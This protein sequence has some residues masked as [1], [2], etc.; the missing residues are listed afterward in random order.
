MRQKPKRILTDPFGLFCVK[1]MVRTKVILYTLLLCTSFVPVYVQAVLYEPGETLNP[2]CLPS[3]P[4]CRVAT[5]TRQFLNLTHGGLLIA[6]STP[7]ATSN[8]LYNQGGVLYWNGAV[9]GG[10]SGLTTIGP[11]GQFQ[12]GPIITLATSSTAFNGLTASTTITGSGNTL[13]FTN[14]LAGLL[15][16]GGG[17]TGIAN[18]SANG[19]LIGSTAG[20]SWQ[21]VATSSLGLV[22]S[23]VMEGTN[24]YWTQ[25]RFNAAVL[26]T[27]S[28]PHLTV[29]TSTYATVADTAATAATATVALALEG[30]NASNYLTLSDWLATTTD[31]LTEGSANLYFTNARADGRIAAATS[32]LRGMLVAGNGLA[33][34]NS[35]GVFTNSGV[36][37]L[38]GLTGN[39]ATSSL[40]IALSDTTGTLPVSRGGT[41]ITSIANNAVLIGA[42][43]TALA[44]TS[45]GDLSV[46][47]GLSLTG[48]SAALLGGS[49]TVALDIPGLTE[50]TG[51]ESS[52]TIALYDTSESGTR[53]ITRANFLQGL[54]SALTY[55][56]T[57]DANAN[58]PALTD[59]TGSAGNTYVADTATT[60]LDL[61]SGALSVN[62]GDMLI[63]NGTVWQVAPSGSNVAS[64]FGRTGA[65]AASSGDYTA[66]QITFVATSTIAATNV[67]AAIEELFDEGGLTSLNGLT[68]SA[69]AFDNDTNV[70][71]SSAGAT[72]TL[73]WSGQLAA[74]RGG[75][76]L[77]S[78]TAHQLLIG[79]SAGDGWTQVATS[80][81]GL[82]TTDVAEGSNLYWT[83]NRFNTALLATSS[84]M[85]LSVSTST[86]AAV[87]DTA[88][89]AD[90]ATTAGTSTVALSLSGFNPAS[91][92][93]L[94]DWNATTTD[95]LAEGLSNLYWTDERFDTRLSAT[96]TLPNLTTL[97]GLTDT[98]TE[99]ATTTNLAAGVLTVS[100][101]STLATTTVT[102]LLSAN[103]GIAL[104]SG[105]PLTTTN[106]LYNQGGD[107][108]WN[109]SAVGAGDGL[110]TDNGADIHFTTGNVGIGAT[111]PATA[112][113][114]EDHF[115]FDTSV[116]ANEQLRIGDNP[117]A[118]TFANSWDQVV[119]YGGTGGA[120]IRILNNTTGTT[121]A[122]GG[123][124]TLWSDQSLRL[125]HQENQPLLFGTYATERLRITGD[126]DVGVGTADPTSK[127]HVLETS[128][129]A[130]IPAMVVQ[131]GGGQFDTP[132]LRLYD[133]G[134]NVNNRGILEF[135]H[136]N[137]GTPVVASRVYSEV[138]SLNAVNGAKLYLQTASNN[139]GSYNANQLVL[140]NDGN[141][142]IGDNAPGANLE[143]SDAT[144]ATTLR[145]TS[146]AGSWSQGDVFSQLEFYTDDS[147]MTNTPGAHAAI[148][149][150]HTR[151]GASHSFADAGLTF[152]TLGSAADAVL[153]ERMRIAEDGK[154]AIGTA[155]TTATNALL[156][157]AGNFDM[158][159]G[160]EDSGRTRRFVIGGA[161]NTEASAFASLIFNNY[162]NDFADADDYTGAQID[163]YNDGGTG[164]GRMEFSVANSSTTQATAL[165]I[166]STGYVGVGTNEPTARLAV[167]GDL[168]QTP[169]NPTIVGGLA[170]TS[171][172]GAFRITVVDDYAYVTGALARTLNVIDVS[173]PSNPTIVGS[174]TSNDLATVSN[175]VVAGRYAYVTNAADGSLRVIDISDP[176]NPTIVGGVRDTTT[177]ANMYGLDVV[178]TYAY[179]SSYNDESFSV[180][181]ISDP[182]NPMI[183]GN[184]KD[185]VD[186]RG[187]YNLKVAGE[188]AYA[189]SLLA[190]TFV[191]IDIADPTN[192]TIV[193]TVQDSS[194][195]NGIFDIDVAG[196]YAYAVN[197]IDDSL[198]IIDIADP[199]NPTIVGGIKSSSLNDARGV[200]VAG[201]YAYIA[202]YGNDSLQII[203]IADPTNPTIVAGVKDTTLLDGARGIDVVGRYAYM[204]MQTADSMQIIDLYGSDL[205]SA[206]IGSLYAGDIASDGSLQVM[207]SSISSGL[208]VGGDALFGGLVSAGGG[209]V[210]ANATPATTTNTL[211]N[212]GGTLYWDGEELGG[213]L[214]TRNGAD[215][216][217]TTGNVGIGTT[218]PPTT[219]AIEDHFFFDTSVAGREQLR[220]GDNPS[221]EN[222]NNTWDQ[223]VLYGGADGAGIRLFNDDTGTGQ[224]GGRLVLWNDETLR[225]WHQGNQALVFGTNNTERMR[226]TNSGTVG[227][228]T[229]A[230]S[231]MLHIAGGN[232][233]FDRGTDTSN[234][235]RSLTVGGARNSGGTEFAS[236]IFNN[237]DD[238]SGAV[239]YT[240][241]E[242]NVFNDGGDGRG[243]LEFSVA[244][245]STLST[246]LTIDST[247]YV[248]I[249]DTAPGANLEISDDTATTTLR[250]TSRAGT[251]SEGDVFSQLEFYT[252]DGN[253]DNTP[254]AHAAIK[255]VHT[256]AGTNHTF[257]DA[258]LTFHTL[259]GS[260]D[261]V[262]TERMRI[263]EDGKVGI[264]TTD[265]YARLTVAPQRAPPIVGGIK[266]TSLD[267]AQAVA[268]SGDFAYVVNTVNDSFRIIDVS[269]PTSPNI[270]GGLQSTSFLNGAADVAVSGQYA[271]VVSQSDHSFHIIDVSDPTTPSVAGSIE[272]NPLFLRPNGIT[273]AGRYAYVTNQDDDSLRII[274]V[275]DPTSPS[276]VGGIKDASL[277]NGA[278]DVVVS[279]RY[280]YVLNTIDDS[281][282]VID[283]Y[284]PTTPTIVGGVKDASLL[285]GA[286]ALAL[287]GHHVYA[288][289]SFSDA[290]RV[291]DVSDPQN[292]IIVG[293]VQDT[294]L[295]DSPRQI[296]VAGRYAYV[297]AYGDDSLRIIDIS[298]PTGPTIVGGVKDVSLL[299]GAVGL[300]VSG[301]SAYVANIL[302]DSLRII[303]LEGTALAT[304]EVGALK[305]GALNVLS[306]STVAQN[307]FVGAG[308]NVG[309]NGIQSQGALAVGTAS[310]SSHFA[311][312][313]GIGT[314]E[315][316]GSLNVVGGSV[317]F[318][319]GIDS[320]PTNS[321]SLNS[322]LIVANTDANTPNIFWA[323]SNHNI[324]W[325]G[326]ED[327]QFSYDNGTSLS[328][329]LTIQAGGDLVVDSINTFFVDASANSVSIGDNTP[330]GKLEVRQTGTA[331]IFN[332][333]DGAT[334]VLSVI[335]GGQVRAFSSHVSG[336]PLSVR[337]NNN[338]SDA[339]GVQVWL[340]ASNPGSN[341]LYMEFI[342]GAS[343]SSQAG[344]IRGNSS[345]G[346][347][348]NTTSDRRVKDNIVDTRYGLPDLLGVQARDYTSVVAGGDELFTGFVAQEL[349]EH[350]PL[351][352]SVGD[353]DEYWGV[354]YGQ[355]TP[356]LTQGIQDL[357][358]LT[359]GSDE[360]ALVF[361]SSTFP[362]GLAPALASLTASSSPLEDASGTPTFAGR[363]F[364]RLAAWFADTTNTITEFIA[365]TIRARD[366]L[367]VGE[368][369]VSEE[370][371]QALL[372]AH[373]THTDDSDDDSDV[374]NETDNNAS[375]PV[376]IVVI[377]SN[378]ATVVLGATYSDLGAI[379]SSTDDALAGLEVR[380]F[381][382]DASGALIEVDTV[383]ID[384]S[385]TTT[386][387]ITYR[388]V[389]GE[390][391]TR[392]ETNRDIAVV[393]ESESVVPDDLDGSGEESVIDIETG[394]TDDTDESTVEMPVHNDFVDNNPAPD[395]TGDSHSGQEHEGGES[396]N[397][398]NNLHGNGETEG[399]GSDEAIGAGA[400]PEA[401]EI[402]DNTNLE[403]ADSSELEDTLDQ[404]DAE[405]AIDAG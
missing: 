106:T 185:T 131:S 404:T 385:T 200:K 210:L 344:R 2:S 109:G 351:A 340:S 259:G 400:N 205:A 46:G 324:A 184:V 60:T 144:S 150:V 334:N 326:G 287:T 349:Y 96:T 195:L 394:T 83:Q 8:R 42:G 99:N 239:D 165:T 391:V 338:G 372:A 316:T 214:W 101:N 31:A 67:Q 208:N 204:S 136:S 367:C 247:G 37:S 390:G 354:D 68:G 52:D 58:S 224:N 312:Q 235:T 285:N 159:R 303:D 187:T 319:A 45:R 151:A 282:R 39:V 320:F 78:V 190:D 341:N 152:H 269:D 81:L 1:S 207:E 263:A 18:P 216:H 132:L 329:Y 163:V 161:R 10:G 27:S 330:D 323:D 228:G 356:L 12:S 189:T 5:S 206:N 95:A 191:V 98:I 293:G 35:T 172:N 103:Q 107:L 299:N 230:P 171:L 143:I 85:H 71:I 11:Q 289:A 198:R 175:V 3:D 328:S 278:I 378:P 244:D 286:Y 137:A 117:T 70:T 258:G 347:A 157:V 333:Y 360:D 149:A 362:D 84:L 314:A 284:D 41:G 209:L 79:N 80:S 53:K 197:Y 134:T 89:S 242:I 236:L 381:Q 168:S 120:G 221:A 311:G 359:F 167:A 238:N 128:D 342:Y 123:R 373:T 363:F 270:I 146:R 357:S 139:S 160:L 307:L 20:G 218:T 57:W 181:D 254:G 215:I 389:D 113:T 126:G 345:G 93:S 234:I 115:Y 375:A 203:D 260:S 369:C 327:L 321:L 271:Y 176:T 339:D 44:T 398:E 141:V 249:G 277:L 371:L 245:A 49:A 16:A 201:R 122:D 22:T 133:E 300:F 219:L 217:F 302:D 87:A 374:L 309:L 21:Q 292:P 272:D 59:A 395:N 102:Q 114:I 386:Y 166:D 17:G 77:G 402:A 199:T 73:G 23:D 135:A 50:V 211:Y 310:S 283:V 280:A 291:I 392:A 397:T 19:I 225:L 281:L 213:G 370:Q 317:V 14:T 227:I 51:V 61:G 273:L 267:G 9:L 48:G 91:Y 233:I 148:R 26:A 379:A 86:Y 241:A 29:G 54:T 264:G 361:A 182:T 301:R 275:S 56:G 376:E 33:Y 240:G 279:G 63:H 212:Q 140:S 62:P 65:I 129:S 92:L 348:Y 75:T 186:L 405:Q 296:S 108:Y 110:W 304:A 352:V 100:G 121:T 256:R 383:L 288:T 76:G 28:L 393:E 147:D 40:G 382:P 118:S 332:L 130:T 262:L 125:W 403:D 364:E 179:V 104:A 127:L 119:L 193:G 105:T 188:Y 32:T 111:S 145:L 90:A 66:S 346:V 138:Q 380:A 325:G 7:N 15:E 295:L 266:S 74:G 248:G 331:D 308:L 274:D 377:G 4:T 178:G 335:D 169:I 194:A 97:L 313:V 38:G 64:V 290:V 298:D 158:N 94:A 251:W 232:G 229:A 55:Q 336:I 306:D 196:R 112:L 368:T 153:T 384:T 237:Y 154:V 294:S 177:L 399:E 222:F 318:G 116:T 226:I 250:I 257:A 252:N 164:A 355:L 268:V 170:T 337:N 246:A 276:I 366:Q 353:E 220:I 34:N 13:T 350:Y 396:G 88:A 255:A 358:Q 162:D 155:T 183:V 243:R 156:T 69:Q 388:V 297:A 343:G 173:R 192:P 82:L 322:Q 365:G 24:L 6:S 36:L 231:A 30:F 180:I 202:T 305:T 315:P 142:G 25:E 253:M 265:P 223:L 43:S 387:T 261:A 124:L 72:H 401:H 174:I 47:S